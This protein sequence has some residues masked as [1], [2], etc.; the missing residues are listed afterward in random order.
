[1]DYDE[2]F[3]KEESIIAIRSLIEE[4]FKDNKLEEVLAA[5]DDTNFFEVISD[6]KTIN[7]ISD[8]NGEKNLSAEGNSIDWS[9]S[10]C[11]ITTYTSNSLK[12]ILDMTFI[13]F[14]DC[15]NT[16]GK[17]INWEYKTE[18]ISLVENPSEYIDD[19]D[20]P[21]AIKEKKKKMME[22]SDLEGLI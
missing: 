1:M 4:S 11:S 14:N 15:L 7:G 16:I 17:K 13:Q 2:N 6:I 22:M 9:T 10:V 21:L 3:K 8:N 20:H 12:D 18:T 5:I 19:S